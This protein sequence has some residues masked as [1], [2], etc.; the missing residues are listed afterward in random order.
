[1]TILKMNFVEQVSLDSD[2][3]I[4]GGLTNFVSVIS[5]VQI[6]LDFSRHNVFITTVILGNY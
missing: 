1:M 3:D 6:T 2:K 5:F 4:Y